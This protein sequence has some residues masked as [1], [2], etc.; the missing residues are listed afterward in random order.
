MQW[1]Q[2]GYEAN[3]GYIFGFSFGGQLASSIGKELSLRNH[4]LANIDS[5][6]KVKV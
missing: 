6:L 2:D 4:I 3:N 1:F 5:K